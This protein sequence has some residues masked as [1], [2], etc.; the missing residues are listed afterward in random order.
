M[1][2][3]KIFGKNREEIEKQARDKYGENYFIISIRELS[4]KNIFG[5]IKKEFEVSIGVLEQ[6]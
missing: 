1:K 5:V 3:I 4:R 2:T 6:Y